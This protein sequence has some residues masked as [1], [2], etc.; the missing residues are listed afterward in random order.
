MAKSLIS[1]NTGFISEDLVVHWAPAI[2]IFI[3]I[4]CGTF[5]SLSESWN[6]LCSFGLGLLENNVQSVTLVFNAHGKSKTPDIVF[7]S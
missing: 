4:I 6:F 1:L 7:K 5:K 3:E 2:G